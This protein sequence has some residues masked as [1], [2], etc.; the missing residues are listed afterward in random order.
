MPG[1][2]TGTDVGVLEGPSIFGHDNDGVKNPK[3]EEGF[4]DS[5]WGDGTPKNSAA[6]KVRAL[7]E[8]GM[9]PSDIPAFLRKQAD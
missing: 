4:T 5:V 3:I 2:R 7:E 6:E 1:I 9:A 8:A